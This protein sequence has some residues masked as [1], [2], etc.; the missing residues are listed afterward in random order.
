MPA[1]KPA[2]PGK[3]WTITLTPKKAEPKVMPRDKRKSC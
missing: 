3:K 1:M 2:A